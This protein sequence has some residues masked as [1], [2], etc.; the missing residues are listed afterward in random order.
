MDMVPIFEKMPIVFYDSKQK[1][2]LQKQLFPF[3]YPLLP[4]LLFLIAFAVMRT[5]ATAPRQSDA[6]AAHSAAD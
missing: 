5:L 3:S 6:V 1:A 2:V 4:Q